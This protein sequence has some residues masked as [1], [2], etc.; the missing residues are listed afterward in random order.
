MQITGRKGMFF[1]KL[2][3]AIL[4]CAYSLCAH[5]AES[6]NN[7]S[8]FDTICQ[9]YTEA[10]NSSM[11]KEQLSH[12][13]F[14]NVESRVKSTDALEAHTAVFNLEPARRYSIFKQSAEYSLKKKW[15]CEAVKKLMN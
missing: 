6:T 7:V 11:T 12:Y 4:I 9:I 5:A 15:D 10:V 13:I 1:R 2:I 3:Q 8:G 14:N